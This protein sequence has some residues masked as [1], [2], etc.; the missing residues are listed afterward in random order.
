MHI[1]KAARGVLLYCVGLCPFT[2]N[3]SHPILFLANFADNV[4]LPVNARVNSEG[5]PRSVVL[6]SNSYGHTTLSTPSR[7]M[8][9]QIGKYFQ[10]GVMPD[11]GTV[12]DPDLVPFERWHIDVSGAEDEADIALR[13]VMLAPVVGVHL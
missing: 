8:A 4:T 7:C 11:E 5:F 6:V 12:C 10:E 13:E 1:A 3:T 9:R 2:G